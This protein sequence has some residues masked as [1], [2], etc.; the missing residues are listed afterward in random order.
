MKKPN[1][2]KTKRLV[3][4][5]TRNNITFKLSVSPNADEFELLKEE[6]PELIKVDMEGKIKPPPI[7]EGFYEELMKI[8]AE[9]FEKRNQM[10]MTF[11]E[12]QERDMK[13]MLDEIFLIQ[14]RIDEM[15]MFKEEGN[16]KTYTASNTD[17]DKDSPLFC[18]LVKKVINENIG[19]KADNDKLPLSIVIQRQFPNALKAVAECSQYGNKKY[20]ETDKDWCNLHRV[21]N[22]VE[23][24]SNAMMRHFL[25]AGK[26]LD[27]KDNETNLEHVKHMVWNAL[28]LLEVIEQQKL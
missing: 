25:A 20:H 3:E 18:E 5:L 27:Q 22:G 17:I 21:D 11:E 15:T 1:L 26:E 23:R 14:N 28:S 4:F 13:R 16:E 8:N 7:P 24:Y 12:M 19:K 9:E 2:E 6:F 10:K